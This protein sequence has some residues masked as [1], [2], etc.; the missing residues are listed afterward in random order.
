VLLIFSDLQKIMR[1]EIVMNLQHNFE[2]GNWKPNKGWACL[3]S[4]NKMRIKMKI[5]GNKWTW[6]DEIKE[7]GGE[8]QLGKINWEL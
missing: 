2:R 6:S 7:V 1:I 8:K 4:K 3:N 5:E